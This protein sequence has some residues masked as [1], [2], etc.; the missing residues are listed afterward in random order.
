MGYNRESRNNPIHFPPY[1]FKKK[2]AKVVHLGLEI[3]K[4]FIQNFNSKQ[5][6]DFPGSPLV[7][8]LPSNSGDMG[9]ILSWRTRIP[10]AVG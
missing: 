8:N 7:K 6:R 1:L 9:S 5:C 3:E 10:Q 4:L 2:K